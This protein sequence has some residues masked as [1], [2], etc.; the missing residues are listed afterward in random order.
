MINKFKDKEVKFVIFTLFITIAVAAISAAFELT[1]RS[2]FALAF[3]MFI[4][5]G[6]VA[7]RQNDLFLKKLLVFG[8]AAGITELLADC[9]LVKTTGTLIYANN[10]LMVACSHLYMPF[11]WA[12]LLIQNGYLG[13]LISRKEK[14]W[15]SILITTLIGFAVIP[16]FEHWAKAAGWWYYENTT[17]ILNTPY[18]I[19]L[20]GGLIC[21]VLPFFFKNIHKKEFKWQILLGMIEGL[22][23]WA[24]YFIA[25]KLVG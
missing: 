14:M 1:W 16:L 11:A 20:E 24:S 18:Y 12:V 22:W 19:I 9:W 3:G 6:W 15:V 2:A 7:F 25:F 4:L 17:M 10:E 23:I 5:L 21:S 8:I 13:W